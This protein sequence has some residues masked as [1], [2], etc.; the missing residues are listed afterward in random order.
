MDEQS[1]VRL[2]KDLSRMDFKDPEMA[3]NLERSIIL[4]AEVAEQIDDEQLVKIV[5][6]FATVGVILAALHVLTSGD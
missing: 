3:Q 4:L 6:G 1:L 5:K 2:R